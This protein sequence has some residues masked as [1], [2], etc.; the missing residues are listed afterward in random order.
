MK[1]I[2]ARKLP[3]IFFTG[4]Y[5]SS[6]LKDG[7]FQMQLLAYFIRYFL[8]S[9]FDLWIKLPSYFC[10]HNNLTY[11][12]LLLFHSTGR[13]RSPKKARTKTWKKL[14]QYQLNPRAQVRVTGIPLTK[15]SS[16]D[17][18]YKRPKQN[19]L[20]WRKRKKETLSEFVTKLVFP[21]KSELKSSTNIWTVSVNITNQP[22]CLGPNKST[23]E[24]F[25]LPVPF[26]IKISIIYNNVQNLQR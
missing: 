10:F 1:E 3:I 18:I 23:K 17:Q 11:I 7:F 5:E 14:H 6:I 22:R 4:V 16:K 8:T 20:F 12:D 24:T 19:L 2:L 9:L 21:T 25:L 13:R 15:S 26:C